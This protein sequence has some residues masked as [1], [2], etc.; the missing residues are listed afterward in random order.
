MIEFLEALHEAAAGATDL[1]SLE[2][3]FLRLSQS[4]GEYHN[5]G[6]GICH[7]LHLWLRREWGFVRQTQ[8]E[9]VATARRWPEHSGDE[10]YPVPSP[11][12]G[13]SAEDYYNHASCMQMW[14]PGEPYADARLRLLRFVIDELKSASI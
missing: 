7:Q 3:G 4:M 10:D 14:L 12:A 11:C 8:E 9:F 13:M 1:Q 5:P 2:A 6:I